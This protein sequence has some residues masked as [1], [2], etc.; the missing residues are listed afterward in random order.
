MTRHFPSD[1]VPKAEAVRYQNG[2]AI[3]WDRR[4]VTTP[5]KAVRTADATRSKSD[6]NT[7]EG[8][9][10]NRKRM[11]TCRASNPSAKTA[12]RGNREICGADEAGRKSRRIMASARRV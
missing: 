4:L 9:C 7:T 11:K 6:Q 2:R 3:P 8:R 12:S 10:P 1:Q 5:A